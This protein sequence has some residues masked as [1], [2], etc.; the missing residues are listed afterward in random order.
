MDATNNIKQRIRK[1]E[2]EEDILTHIFK[3]FLDKFDYVGL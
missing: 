2:E 1:K 3:G